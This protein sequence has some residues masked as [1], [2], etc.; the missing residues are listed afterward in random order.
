MKN[1][2]RDPKLIWLDCCCCCC[3]WKLSMTLMMMIFLWNKS[4]K[5]KNL[6]I[7]LYI[8][9]NDNNNRSLL[10]FRFFSILNDDNHHHHC[11]WISWYNELVVRLFDRQSIWGYNIQNHKKRE[12]SVHHDYIEYIFIFRQKNTPKMIWLYLNHTHREYSSSSSSSCY[13]WKWI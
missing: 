9:S 4:L 13:Y 7:Y 6:F 12:S 3:C 10:L 1:R 11:Q 8:I 5:K 2:H